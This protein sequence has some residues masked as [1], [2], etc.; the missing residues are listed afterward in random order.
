MA[1]LKYLW[2]HLLT[3]GYDPRGGI[4]GVAG[5][6][7][8]FG[9]RIHEDLKRSVYGLG[10]GW[11]GVD[12]SITIDSLGDDLSS[13]EDGASF[14]REKLMR[15]LGIPAE[16]IYRGRQAGATSSMEHFHELVEYDADIRAVFQ[17]GQQLTIQQD[18]SEGLSEGDPI[19]VDEDGYLRP[20]D[21]S[22]HGTPYGRVSDVDEEEGSM[23]ISVYGEINAG[24]SMEYCEF[25]PFS[26]IG[27][28]DLRE[29][30]NDMDL[31]EEI[32]NSSPFDD[33]TVDEALRRL[34]HEEEQDGEVFILGDPIQF[35]RVRQAIEGSPAID[36]DDRSLCSWGV[37]GEYDEARVI[38]RR[39]GRVTERPYSYEMLDFLEA[40]DHE[41]EE[42]IPELLARMLP[43]F[44]PVYSGLKPEQV[45]YTSTIDEQPGWFGMNGWQGLLAASYILTKAVRRAGLED[46]FPGLL[47]P[48]KQEA[49]FIL[50]SSMGGFFFQ[51]GGPVLAVRRPA[52]KHF[53][54]NDEDGTEEFHNEDGPVLAFESG[55]KYYALNGIPVPEWLVEMDAAEI[56]PAW[57]AKVTNVDV[58]RELIRKVGIERLLE[59]LHHEVLDERENYTLYEIDIG[60]AVPVG[61]HDRTRRKYLRMRNPSTGTWH[62]EA[63]HPD[64]ETVQQALNWRATGWTGGEW[65][66]T[67]IT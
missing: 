4:A 6:A 12:D 61:P 28:E 48:K 47:D 13:L 5:G 30:M 24:S 7:F 19:T 41:E 15:G 36:A 40:C 20:S 62:M 56:N 26:D 63:V 29:A 27:S 35:V 33:E 66:P 9:R 51:K 52:E 18:E 17:D 67:E 44:S 57:I 10:E 46:D 45:V 39:V 1:W 2:Y 64:C 59:Q 37:M 65:N 31:E 53:R 54:W 16:Y 25:D 60:A 55:R 3:G 8:R 50:L 23:S 58:R 14:Y 34:L 43:S 49:R 38:N 21:E 42:D 32:P 22:E 11:D